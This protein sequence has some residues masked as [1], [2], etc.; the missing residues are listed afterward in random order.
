MIPKTYRIGLIFC[1]LAS[2]LF[3]LLSAGCDSNDNYLEVDFTRTVSIEELDAPAVDRPLLRAAVGAM[4]SPRETFES[5]RE[6]LV[7]LSNELDL[8]LEFTQRKTY[9]EINALLGRG[10]IDLAFIC[11]G[12][13]VRGK[14]DYDFRLLAA[15][16][17]DGRWEYHSY[18]IVHEESPY[19]ELNDL[20]GKIFAFT[21][22]DSNTGRMVPMYWIKN[23]GTTPEEF[24]SDVIYTYSHDNSILAVSKGLVD[25]AAVDHL[26]WEYLLKTGSEI[27]KNTRVIKTSQ[28][29]GMPPV[30]VSSSLDVR[31][32]DRIVQVLLNM[33]EN[34]AEQEI[35]SELMIERFVPAED[36]WY[37]SIRD[38]FR[39]LKDNGNSSTLQP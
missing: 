15:P 19:Q 7:Y 29:F 13:Y 11:S 24:F 35:L 22:P 31:T 17:V 32:A 26:I 34:V 36:E 25:G 28:P 6:I 12:P 23:M 5:Y 2:G 39:I 30:V 3:F 10:E 16:V 38:I 20:R 21:D 8:Q 14:E 33:H 27:T 37:D 9:E 4:I 18:L 1:L